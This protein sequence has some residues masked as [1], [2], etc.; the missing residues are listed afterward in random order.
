MDRRAWR[1][2]VHGVTE[3][4]TAEPLTLLP[5]RSLQSIEQ[6][7]LCHTVGSH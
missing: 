2:T 5:Y 1:A 4:D 7:P 6:S 3:S